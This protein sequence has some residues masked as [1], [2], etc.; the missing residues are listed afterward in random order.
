VPYEDEQPARFEPDEKLDALARETIGAAIEVHRQMGAGLDEASY[1]AGLEIEL[2]LR[3]ISFERQVNVPVTYKGIAVGTRKIDLI[4]GRRLVVEI[5]AIE[6]LGKVHFAQVRTYLKLTNLQLRLLFNFNTAV[7]K[8]G[9]KR[10]I[11]A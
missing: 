4:V 3:G 8:D 10:V 2:R 9:M 6:E 7:L 5:K 1:Q 11:R